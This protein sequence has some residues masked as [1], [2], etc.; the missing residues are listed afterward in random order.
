MNYFEGPLPR[1]FAH[2]GASGHYPE[3]TLAAFLAAIEQGAER[4]ELDVH[5]SSDG[6]VVICHD[7]TLDRC[8]D[9]SGLVREH[10]F[11][12]L[13]SLDAGAGFRAA[14]GS[15][16]YA[17]KGIR[18]PALEEL[19]EA[20]PGTPLNIEIK[21]YEPAIETKVIETLDRFNAR[22][23][24]LLAAEDDR[25]MTRIRAAAPGIATGSSAS[26][27]LEF[28]VAMQSGALAGYSHAGRALQVPPVFQDVEVVTADFVEAAHRSGVE[29]HVW[30][31]NDSLQM[32]ALLEIGVDGI[33]SDYPA[34][35]FSVMKEMG[36]R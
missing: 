13:K 10:T 8:S 24:V 20:L 12:G 14:D 4:L 17:G 28:F 6:V 21:Q 27:A 2:R 18:I 31:V 9:G 7:E 36:L 34:R 22:D 5:A 3:N 26:E 19:L 16:P 32:R 35:A 30:T 25:I 1:L 33:M 23:C 29:V 11:E 15:R